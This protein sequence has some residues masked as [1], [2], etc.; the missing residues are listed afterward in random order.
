MCTTQKYGED[1]QINSIPYVGMKTVGNDRKTASTISVTIFF[2][3][4]KSETVKSETK[5]I[6]EILENRKRN[7][8]DE[9]MS[10]QIGNW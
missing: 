2:S 9:N 1:S 6:S 7:N 3:E 5:K 8:T 10:V 4:T